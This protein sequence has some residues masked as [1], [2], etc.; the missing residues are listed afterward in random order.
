MSH[1]AATTPESRPL[2]AGERALL[3]WLLTR[4]AEITATDRG[5]ASCFLKQISA[6]RVVGRCGCGCPSIDL[7]LAAPELVV[8]AASATLADVEGYSPEG[9]AIGVILRAREGHL[10][11]LELYARDG[12]L[13]F[14]LPGMEQLQLYW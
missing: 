9:S 4:G 3:E 7:A 2:T 12:K 1:V 14:T 8:S 5:L 13:P 6:L 10:S 11:E